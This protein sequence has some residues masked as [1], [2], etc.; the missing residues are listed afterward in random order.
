VPLHDTLPYP[1]T[2]PLPPLVQ[3]PAA[4]HIVLRGRRF[5]LAARLCLFAINSLTLAL[6]LG[7]KWWLGFPD[8]LLELKPQLAAIGGERPHNLNPSSVDT[9]MFHILQAN[10]RY[11]TYISESRPTFLFIYCCVF[12]DKR[13]VR[14]ETGVLLDLQ[15][16]RMIIYF[17]A[18]V[19]RR[20]C[21]G[22]R[23]RKEAQ[24]SSS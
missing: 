15:R 21:R 10:Q 11:I 6:N 9:T 24:N 1:P 19:I 14:K 13:R 8:Q 5:H 16:Q 17:P 22:D 4:P 20:H 18:C 2:S 23:K 7:G 12:L 3:S